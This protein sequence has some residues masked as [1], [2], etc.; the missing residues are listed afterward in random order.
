MSILDLYYKFNNLKQN[1]FKHQ[2]NLNILYLQVTYLLIIVKLIKLQICCQ[3]YFRLQ[4]NKGRNIQP[5]FQL[6]NFIQTI[7]SLWFP[8]N[9]HRI[10][11][12]TA[13]VQQFY[14]S[15]S[16]PSKL[17]CC[18]A[19]ADDKLPAEP[20]GICRFHFERAY[21]TELWLFLPPDIRK[22]I[23]HGCG[24]VKAAHG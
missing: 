18:Q 9:L 10:L 4:K 16:E 3:S 11:Q 14:H 15:S 2:N 21:Q 20:N 12:C 17:L 23:S 8:V 7:S 5:L 22:H 13:C 6:I 24:D 1:I 19:E